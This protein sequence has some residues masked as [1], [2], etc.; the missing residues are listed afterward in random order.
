MISELG[1]EPNGHFWHGV[2]ELLIASE[3]CDLKGLFSSDPEA[4]A[5]C[6]YGND[7]A[8]LEDLAALLN[9]VATDEDR[10]RQFFQLANSTGCEFDD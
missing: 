9:G 7:R 10:L 1:H 8:V 6:A 3:A 5:F 2:V 4:G